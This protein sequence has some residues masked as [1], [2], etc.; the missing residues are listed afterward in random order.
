MVGIGGS[1]WGC[2]FNMMVWELALRVADL[3]LLHPEILCLCCAF[4]R[5]LHY[6]RVRLVN[7]FFVYSDVL[8]PYA[9]A[10]PWTPLNPGFY[11]ISGG[12]RN[13]FL[14]YTTVRHGK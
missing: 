6:L 10:P 5:A 9:Y 12:C 11:S 2:F 14:F 1:V 13:S 4:L 3:F 7:F 8:T